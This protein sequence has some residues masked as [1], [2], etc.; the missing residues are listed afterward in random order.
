MCCWRKSV[1]PSNAT[2][3]V[4]VSA[5]EGSIVFRLM[6]IFDKVISRSKSGRILPEPEGGFP[7]ESKPPTTGASTA[8]V[9]PTSATVSS[10]DNEAKSDSTQRPK[11]DLN[12]GNSIKDMLS[13]VEECAAK[14]EATAAEAETLE[15]D[16][17]LSK[18]NELMKPEPTDMVKAVASVD[19]ATVDESSEPV[20]AAGDPVFS[21]LSPKSQHSARLIATRKIEHSSLGSFR[22]ELAMSQKEL[23]TTALKTSRALDKA[24]EKDPNKNMLEKLVR[25]KTV[26]KSIVS[27]VEEDE[28]G[29]LTQINQ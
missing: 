12:K 9:S 3:V 19:A 27:N 15:G 1:Y 16:S 5:L 25:R 22:E 18:E 21:I 2:P 8:K 28:E 13:S 6:G 24:M 23:N 17:T 11:P 26:E 14:I 29:E 20:A 7:D 10:V 4:V